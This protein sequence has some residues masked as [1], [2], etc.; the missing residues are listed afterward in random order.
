MILADHQLRAA[1]AAG[2]LVVDPLGPGA[3]QPASID[4]RLGPTVLR[5]APDACMLDA[6]DGQD[7]D[8]EAYEYEPEAPVILRPGEFILGATYERITIGRQF[9]AQVAGKSS[10]ARMGVAMHIT[11]G[12]IDP[13][14]AGMLTLELVNH[15]P[16]PVKLYVGQYVA[17]LQVWALS[18]PAERAYSGHYRDAVGPEA[19]R[20]WQQMVEAG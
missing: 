14:F 15:A 4:L 19:S 11:A 7:C 1:L 8:W 13:G 10:L 6:A 2:T 12:F 20:C 16:I 18:A 5:L 9:A 3:V 17:Q